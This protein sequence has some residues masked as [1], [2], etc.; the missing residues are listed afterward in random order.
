[1][2]HFLRKRLIDEG[3]KK[4][5]TR[6]FVDEEN[7]DYLSLDTFIS[8]LENHPNAFIIFDRKGRT[9]GY[10]QKAAD[11]FG[12]VFA[13]EPM[14]FFQQLFDHKI[15]KKSTYYFKEALKGR[16]QHFHTTAM[17]HDGTYLDIQITFV[18]VVL[19]DRV[20]CV[21]GIFRKMNETDNIFAAIR[22]LNSDFS[23]IHEHV[24]IGLVEYDIE[25]DI[26][27]CSDQVYEMLAIMDEEEKRNFTFSKLLKYVHYHDRSL[28]QEEY[29]KIIQTGQ[30]FS[31]TWRMVR[32][33][34]EERVVFGQ[35]IPQD[36][37]KSK[38]TKIIWFLADLTEK[39]H[40]E[41]QVV[42]LNEKIEQITKNLDVCLWSVDVQ[43]NKVLFCSDVVTKIYGR[44]SEFFRSNPD[45]WK[46]CIHRDDLD[47]VLSNHEVLLKGEILQHEY[48]IVHPDGKVIWVL[49]YSFPKLN[50]KGELVSIEKM[51]VDITKAKENE[52]KV[53]RQKHYDALTNLPNQQSLMN[54]LS[55]WIESYGEK[56]EIFAVFCMDLDNFKRINNSLGRF[57]GDAIL[58]K[59]ANRIEKMVEGKGNVYRLV[60]DE[61]VFLLNLGNDKELYHEFAQEILNTVA[62]PINIE[63]HELYITASI[64]ICFFPADGQ[65][66][67]TLLSN[68]DIALYKAKQLDKNTYQVYVPSIGISA[69]KQLSLEKELR[70][71]LKNNELFIEYQPR[72]DAKSFRVVGAEALVRWKHPDWGVVSPYEFIPIAEEVEL[73]NEIGDWIIGQVCQQLKS[74]IEKKLNVQVISINISPKRFLRKGFYE[75]LRNAVA[76][77]NIRPSLLEIEITERSLLQ[78]EDLV[79]KQLQKIKEF[80][81]RVALDDFGSGFTSLN[82]I[83]N[84]P[85]DTVKIDKS[86]IQHL[87]SEQN[88]QV[89]TKSIIDIAHGLNMKVVGEGVETK[90]QLSLLQK[91]QCD[92]IQGYLFSRPLSNLEMEE[93]FRK[94]QLDP[95]DGVHNFDGQGDRRGYFRI[96]FPQ[97]LLTNLTIVKFNHKPVNV[98]RTEGLLIN[99]GPGGLCLMSHLRL[100]VHDG[101][102]YQFEV[103]I[104]QKTVVL[105]GIIVWSKEVE[106]NIFQYGVKFHISDTERDHLTS[107]LNHF[108]IQ[109]KRKT[110][111]DE[112]HMINE[113]PS[114]YIKKKFLLKRKY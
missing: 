104:M 63:D 34:G 107:L 46:S 55:K 70:K 75:T 41:K 102:V 62:V 52:L 3:R 76:E 73:I 9:V 56:S 69:F 5:F 91:Y 17:A 93:V 33:D 109:I 12:N 106:E 51:V 108:S 105:L 65:D 22:Q 10:N 50:E 59:I 14:P 19:N 96:Q 88:D 26:L 27:T 82:N 58:K 16:P 61:F 74:W 100:P 110:Y 30:S 13:K 18:P 42:E 36:F 29:K 114:R 97:P 32:A 2:P 71:A 40:L 49:D 101:V 4:S 45:Y 43:N 57:A 84:F 39:M 23:E 86:F 92:E 60:G 15:L 78:S 113:D 98:G 89:I 38:P 68:A 21:A 95:V 47:S 44:D 87:T 11:F 28:F 99:I 64:G 48:R 112:K 94:R 54:D 25:Y 66:R 81:V 24:S 85:I 83:K 77:A 6:F 111:F 90:E 7:N 1:M 8:I 72:V 31:M 53:D 20:S 67:K 80:G 103:N 37:F 35:G 79:H